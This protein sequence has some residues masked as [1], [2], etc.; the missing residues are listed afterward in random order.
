MFGYGVIILNDCHKFQC[1]QY[2]VS[3]GAHKMC[4]KIHSCSSVKKYHKHREKI[5]TEL[6]PLLQ[7][8]SCCKACTMLYVIK[9]N[10][11]SCLPGPGQ[12]SLTRLT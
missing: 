11:R 9:E 1:I 10:S 5:P 3:I 7:Q 2:Q 8:N 6:G 4:A 12:E